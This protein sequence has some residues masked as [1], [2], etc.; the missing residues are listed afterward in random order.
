M[1]FTRDPIE[2]AR[3]H[4]ARLSAQQSGSQLLSLFSHVK[5]AA[6]KGGDNGKG[7]GKEKERPQDDRDEAAGRLLW[8]FS[9]QRVEQSVDDAWARNTLNSLEFPDLTCE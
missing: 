1:T 4:I 6:A 7:K 9:L 5:V 8:A 2:L 3:K